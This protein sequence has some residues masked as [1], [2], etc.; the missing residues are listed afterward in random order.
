MSIE[1]IVGLANPGRDYESTRHNAG[2]WFVEQLAKQLNVTLNLNTK[3]HAQLGQ[4]NAAGRVVRLAIPTTYMNESGL[5]VGAMSRFYKIPAENILIAHD[6]I[7]LPP[8][9]ARLKFA[10]GEGGHNGLRS[11]VQHLGCQQFFRLRVGVGHP[12]NSNQVADYV[13]K[14]PKKNEQPLIDQSI[15]E[16]LDVV[17]LILNGE[18]EKA[19]TTLHTNTK[20]SATR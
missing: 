18:T 11:I 9:A 17:P 10:G 6:E 2:A 19:M 15:V 1:L 7:D 8:G 5:S 20:P 3:L 12:G 14:A 13:L 4:T 16:A